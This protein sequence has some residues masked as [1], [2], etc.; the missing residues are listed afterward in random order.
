MLSLSNLSVGYRKGELVLRDISFSLRQGGMLAIIGPNG[1]GKT[2]LLRCINAV[3]KPYTG[4]V[5]IEDRNV[6]KMH[7]REI[8][9]QIGYVPQNNKTGNMT[10]FDSVL[11]GRN[12][13]IGFRSSQEDLDKVGEVLS[14]LS[15]DHFVT[16]DTL[17]LSG[18]ELQKVCIARALVQEPRI[19][20]LDEPTSNLDLKNQMEIM[21]IIRKITT[22]N[23]LSAVMSIHDLNLAFRFADYLIL[24]DKGSII[25]HGSPHNITAGTLSEVYGVE[26][27]L[28][29]RNG[30]VMVNIV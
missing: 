19:F 11:L 22:D 1:A 26:V 16:R 7:T 15:L 13:H 8:A 18:G 4:V 3:L 21:N 17:E 30:Y 29:H 24:L 25:A 14:K 12:P 10:V 5:E 27:E 28:I 23:K 20:L 6:L 2:T 9:R